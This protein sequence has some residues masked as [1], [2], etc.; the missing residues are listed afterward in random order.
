MTLRRLA[1]RRARGWPSVSRQQSKIPA[2]ADGGSAPLPRRRGANA[3]GGVAP[4]SGRSTEPPES[5]S[6]EGLSGGSGVWVWLWCLALVSGL[7]LWLWLWLASESHPFSDAFAYA[8]ASSSCALSLAS[9]SPDHRFSADPLALPDRVCLSA[10]SSS[11]FGFTHP[12][13]V[14]VQN[15]SR[16]LSIAIC[17]FLSIALSKRY[18]DC[19]LDGSGFS[20]A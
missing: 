2:T 7:W 17:S 18:I 3:T 13:S 19:L 14:S 5:G 12:L 11:A 4:K 16:I 15:S 6:W 10:I 1:S 20:V 8:F 9:A